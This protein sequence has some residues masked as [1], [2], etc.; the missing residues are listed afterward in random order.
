MNEAKADF[1]DSQVNEPWAASEFGA[2]EREKVYRM[3]GQAQF[4]G[5]MRVIEPGCGTGRLTAILADVVG[6]GGLVHALDISSNM[7]EAARRRV[8]TRPNVCLECASI[9]SSSFDPQ[10]YDV[11][12]CHNVFPH[13]DDK[14]A[15]VAHL[16][17]A[18]KKGGSFIVLHFMSSEEINDMHRKVHTSVLNDLIPP[19]SQMRNI[20]EASGLQVQLIKDDE[21]GYLLCATT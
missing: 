20:F 4:R 12:V 9:E 3:L 2:Q 8:G 15:A 6:P 21:A 1:F 11:V 17:A 5:G 13:F 10:S 16:A 14:P 19:E 7:I 18:L